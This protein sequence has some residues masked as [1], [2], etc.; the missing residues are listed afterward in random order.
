MSLSNI[1]LKGLCSE[2]AEQGKQDR[3]RADQSWICDLCWQH[4]SKTL[5]VT[6]EG[7]PALQSPEWPKLTMYAAGGLFS[8]RMPQPPRRWETL[9]KGESCRCFIS[10]F[11]LTWILNADGMFTE[12][13]LFHFPAEFSQ[14][15]VF[16]LTRLFNFFV[17]CG[18]LHL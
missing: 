1:A 13:L 11:C 16:P 7:S 18:L 15:T 6:T 17:N 12:W 8:Y 2:E 9:R 3:D 14:C 10:A 4:L 5:C